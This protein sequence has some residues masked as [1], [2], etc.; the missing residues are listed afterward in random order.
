MEC[1]KVENLSFAYPNKTDK[2]LKNINLTINQGEFLQIF[3]P[4]ETIVRVDC[5]VCGKEHG[6]AL[7]AELTRRG[8]NIQM[9]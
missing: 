4:N 3:K 1:F 6:D 5:E 7:I 9:K 2:A 8:Y